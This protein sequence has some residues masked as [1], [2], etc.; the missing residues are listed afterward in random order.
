MTTASR[1]ETYCITEC[2]ELDLKYIRQKTVELWAVDFLRSYVG[3][4]VGGR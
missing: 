3:V 2:E 4:F 1:S